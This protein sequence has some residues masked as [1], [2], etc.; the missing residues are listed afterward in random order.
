MTVEFRFEEPEAR[1]R[2]RA[3]GLVEVHMD[4]LTGENERAAAS[5]RPPDGLRP[6]RQAVS[7]AAGWE[8]T[9]RNA[10][11]LGPAPSRPRGRLGAH[12]PQRPL[13]LRLRQEVQALPRGAGLVSLMHNPAAAIS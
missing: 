10:P 13:P 11:C 5:A 3:G 8:R 9:S 7:A 12:Q 6:Q 1:R 4:P 2:R